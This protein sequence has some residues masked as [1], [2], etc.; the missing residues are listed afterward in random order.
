[1]H[2]IGRRQVY[3]AVIDHI[4]R[5]NL[6]E[7]MHDMRIT[8][9]ELLVVLQDDDLSNPFLIDPYICVQHSAVIDRRID[10]R[11]IGF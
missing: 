7:R 11:R 4:S 1:M 3:F 9:A 6:L 10:K 5:D 8:A 2:L